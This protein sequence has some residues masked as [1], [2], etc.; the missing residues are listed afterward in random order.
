MESTTE[1]YY[2]CDSSEYQAFKE[3]IGNHYLEK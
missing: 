2:N 1:H 3:R